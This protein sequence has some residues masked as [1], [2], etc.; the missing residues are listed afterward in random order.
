MK[1]LPVILLS[2]S[3]LVAGA[4]EQ[5]TVNSKLPGDELIHNAKQTTAGFAVIAGF[6]SEKEV[7]SAVQGN[8][9]RSVKLISYKVLHGPESFTQKTLTF[10]CEDSFPVEGSRI[11][12]KRMP[13]PFKRGKLIFSLERDED[14]RLSPFFR[15]ISYQPAA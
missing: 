13:W 4:V 11:K 1:I 9:R 8:W 3:S 10:I 7:F 2:L 6:V 12:T 15:I 14:A 5:I